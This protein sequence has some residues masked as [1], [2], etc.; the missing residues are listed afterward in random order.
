MRATNISIDKGGEHAQEPR[1][2]QMSPNTAFGLPVLAKTGIATDVK[3]GR[4]RARD[5]IADLAE[6]Y[7]DSPA[8]I[9]DALRWELPQLNV[10]A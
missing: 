9:E 1:T 10:A 5:S 8:M 4:S 3:A 6:E 7:G 2:I